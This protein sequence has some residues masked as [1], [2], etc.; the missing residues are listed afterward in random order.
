MKITADNGRLVP[1]K[2]LIFSGGEVQ[3]SLDELALRLGTQSNK[4]VRIAVQ[5]TDSV[6]VMELVMAVDA[7]R[8][9][10]PDAKLELSMPYVPYARQDRVMNPG[11]ALAV[12]AF[13]DL[14]NSLNFSAV[15]VA[16]VHSDVTLA[17]INNVH[18]STVEQFTKVIPIETSNVVLVAPDA[19]SIKKVST[20][21][22]TF[23]HATPAPMVRA[24]K[25]RNTTTG[26]ITG[27]V[28]YSDHIG[29]KDF[30]IVDDIC[31]GGRTFLEL[32][33]VLRPKTN[34]KI[35]LYVTHGIFSH[36]LNVFDGVIDRVFVAYPFP[37]VDL[38]NPLVYKLN[39]E[40]A[41]A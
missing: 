37:N 2:T 1:R 41:N 24:D 4:R 18:H 33:K 38:T 8:R 23:N 34:G 22:K 21:A 10:V 39:T 31:D 28:V 14:I 32:A 13:T 30:L 35:Y 27:T 6:K 15:Y 17:L 3:F 9:L 7:I 16:D 36:G 5:L 29:D 25:L 11:E 40:F 19:G 20:V 12:K 26:E